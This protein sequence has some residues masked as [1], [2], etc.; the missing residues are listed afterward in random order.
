M[1]IVIRWLPGARGAVLRFTNSLILAALVTL[2]MTGLY[3]LMWPQ[4]AWVFDLHR[5][6]SWILVAL[7]P[8]KAAIVLASLRRGLDRRFDR[9]VML[10]VSSLLAGAALTVLALGYA[11]AWR[12]G[13]VLLWLGAYGDAVISWHWMLALG[14]LLPLGLHV[15]RRW[16]RPKPADFAGRRN[17][18]KLLALG[19]FALAG[20]GAADFIARWRQLPAA[21][22][23]FT[24]S[25][26]TASFSG[27]GYPITNTIGQG[28]TVIDPASYR[29]A[30]RGAVNNPLSLSFA[31]LLARDAA[32]ITATLDCTSG[33]YTTQTWRG[34][35][36]SALLQEAQIHSAQV[37]L[38]LID[39]SGYAA[40]FSYAEA[41]EIL[42]AT[43]AG[44]QLLDHWHGAPV[45]AVAPS[46]RGWQWVKWLVTIEVKPV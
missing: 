38:V 45:R 24:G 17:A 39:V 8:W 42:L 35:P 26:E 19:G 34:L 15:W 23:R 41:G 3:G 1:S 13:P 16:P 10:A 31:D 36:L 9:S 11:W 4:P 12:I 46:R 37:I 28:Q 22:R 33:W 20:W 30:L 14:L 2:T 21:P 6:A 40:A 7:L 18:L 25:Y 27:L 5:G 43:H 29:L 44:G 32:E